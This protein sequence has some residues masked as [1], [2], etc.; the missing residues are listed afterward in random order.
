ME[1]TT[2]FAILGVA[3]SIVGVF[4]TAQ[5]AQAQTREARGT[6][7]AVTDSSLTMKAGAQELTVF[8][9]SDTHLSVRRTERDIQKEQPGRPSPRVNS[10]FEPGQAVLVRYRVENGRNMATDISRVGSA[11]EGS[12]SN[13]AKISAGKVK[14]VTASQL[15]IDDG[16]R[17][18][19][20]GINADTNVLAKG[21]TKATKAAGGSTPI[22]TFVHTGDSVSVSY[23]E[24]GAKMMASEVRVT[25]AAR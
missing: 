13:P 10:F 22:T 5:P 23:H 3:A 24:A 21:A 17:E 7:T 4:A 11:G 25:V 2:R 16:G 6:V 18:L 20:F 8:V 1:N 9:D 14:T 15:V 19:S 12:I